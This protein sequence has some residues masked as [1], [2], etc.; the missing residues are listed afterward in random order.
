MTNHHAAKNLTTAQDSTEYTWYIKPAAVCRACWGRAA[1]VDLYGA[2]SRALA[3]ACRGGS[4][5]A[6]RPR[7]R[8]LGCWRGVGGVLEGA[9]WATSAGPDD[10]IAAFPWALGGSTVARPE[11]VALESPPQEAR[12][13]SRCT[14]NGGFDMARCSRS[15]TCGRI[16]AVAC[17]AGSHRSKPGVVGERVRCMHRQDRMRRASGFRLQDAGC[18]LQAAG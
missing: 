1:V 17:T 8:C 6:R 2:A 10:R 13:A 15:R 7:A 12:P 16:Q 9:I 18:R 5:R 3:A 11:C 4:S 14:K